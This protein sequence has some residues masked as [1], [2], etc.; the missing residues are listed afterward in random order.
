MGACDAYGMRRR[1]LLA[2]VAA[3]AAALAGCSATG[4]PAATTSTRDRT[5]TSDPTTA[6]PTTTD[7]APEPP[8]TGLGA[9]TTAVL[10][11]RDRTLSLLN[12]RRR[13]PSGVVVRAWLSATA[14]A[15]HPARVTATITNET[16]YETA[17]RLGNVAPFDDTPFARPEGN[18]DGG[19]YLA[20]T[21]GHEFATA[22][23]AV[24]RT[25]EGGWYLDES[26]GDWQPSALQLAPGETAVA[27]YGVVAHYQRPDVVPTGRYRFGYGDDALALVAWQSSR[28]GPTADSRFADAS[29]PAFEEMDPAWYHDAGP[30]TPVYLQ[31]STERVEAPGRVS[32]TLHNYLTEPLTGNHYDWS[33]SKLVDGE[34]YHVAPWMIPVPLTPLPPGDTHT[35]TLHAF[36]GRDVDC[37]HAIPLG[38]LGGGRYAFQVNMHPEEGATR[39]ALFD[40]DA[41]PVTVT[42]TDGVS[43]SREDG[44]VTAHGPGMEGDTDGDATLVVERADAADRR[45]VPEQVM[46]RRYRG[47]RNTLPFF[48]PGVTRVELHTD[49]GTVDRVVGYEEGSRSFRFDGEPFVAKRD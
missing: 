11:T 2:S 31:P 13:L 21:D 6:D 12:G 44:V 15:E 29:P 28:P 39:A 23:P 26:P 4:E 38:F 49:D 46:R 1:T 10:E 32:F 14:T 30:E 20:P 25:D 36:H 33:L 42:P 35:W 27:E 45:L 47:L 18:V 24:A 16:E 8:D 19:L 37:R 22:T 9:A 40:L 48:E 34:W 43:A 5:A 41:P 7:D 3:G 17:L